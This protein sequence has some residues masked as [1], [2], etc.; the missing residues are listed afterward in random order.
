MS[1]VPE[2]FLLPL[3]KKRYKK[4]S[5]NGLEKYKL[6]EFLSNSILH[7]NMRASNMFAAEMVFSNYYTEFWTVIFKIWIKYIHLKNLGMLKWLLDQQ[8]KF[9]Q[10]RNKFQV[11]KLKNLQEIRHII[12]QVT[13]IL[14]LQQKIKIEINKTNCNLLLTSNSRQIGTYYSGLLKDPDNTSVENLARILSQFIEAYN[15]DQIKFIYH[16]LEQLITLEHKIIPIKEPLPTKSSCEHPIWLVWAIMNK[17]INK[18][19]NISIPLIDD[20]RKLFAYFLDNEQE[21]Y[22]ILYTYIM[23][24]YLKYVDQIQV[25]YVDILHPKVIKYVLSI[26]YF[27]QRVDTMIQK[28]CFGIDHAAIRRQQEADEQIMLKHARNPAQ[29]KLKI[30]KTHKKPNSIKIKLQL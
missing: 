6:T 5:H 3:G 28:Y 4:T 15:S 12:C 13:A 18:K 7:G 26:N 25:G 10:I 24:T 14:C 2:Q 21:E 8:R 1:T 30:I 11:G 23:I 17:T 29:P 20:L 19:P 9:Q 27:Y 16:W 22:A